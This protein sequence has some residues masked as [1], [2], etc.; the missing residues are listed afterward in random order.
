VEDDAV[1]AG[2]EISRILKAAGVGEVV[3][4]DQRLPVEYCE[5]C[6]AP[7]FPTGEGESVHAEMP[8]PAE[9]A[10]AHLH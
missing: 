2:G 4:L 1:D 10:P 7:L 8:A 3:L 9:S 5:D 6:G